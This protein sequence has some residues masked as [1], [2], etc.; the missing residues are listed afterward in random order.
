MIYSISVELKLFILFLPSEVCHQD[1]SSVPDIKDL[2]G[3]IGGTGGESSPVI[4]H[5]G[6]MLKQKQEQPKL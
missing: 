6:I 5:L 2:D 3:A 1:L 4:I